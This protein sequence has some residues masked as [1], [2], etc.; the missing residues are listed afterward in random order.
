[1]NQEIR[2]QLPSIGSTLRW[3]VRDEASTTYTGVIETAEEFG[4]R[5]YTEAWDRGWSRADKKVVLGDGAVWIWNIADREFPGALQIV[6]LYHA[7]EH[8]WVPI[9]TG[10]A[11][12]PAAPRIPR[13]FPPISGWAITI[14]ISG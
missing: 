1:V 5:V 4:R 7:R 9:I 10:F 12:T 14:W 11:K 8:L 13:Q 6:D 2:C 3:P